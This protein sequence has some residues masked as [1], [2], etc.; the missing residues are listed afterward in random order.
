[1]PVLIT[2][3]RSRIDGQ[4]CSNTS[5]GFVM[6]PGDSASALY[7]EGRVLCRACGTAAQES[8]DGSEF[9]TIAELTEMMNEEERVRQHGED[10]PMATLHELAAKFNQAKAVAVPQPPA[11][12]AEAIP[13]ESPKPADDLGIMPSNVHGPSREARVAAL[14]AEAATLRE[15]AKGL[16][17]QAESNPLLAP[18]LEAAIKKMER[19]AAGKDK[20]ADK[21]L[22][23]VYKC[24][25]RSAEEVALRQAIYAGGIE[26]LQALDAAIAAGLFGK[27]ARPATAKS[28]GGESAKGT[29]TPRRSSSTP[30]PEK[31]RLAMRAH[32]LR[33]E[34]HTLAQVA[35][36]LGIDDPAYKGLR[37]V[38]RLLTLKVA[39]A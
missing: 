3:Q 23:V 6:L 18:A 15:G 5:K 22:P 7:K 26:A 11:P 36:K 2:C 1:M 9:I 30:D 38:Q 24:I 31:V 20:D 28:D 21:L 35:E 25:E 13:V 17:I 37:V 29:P 32:Q 16:R 19:D 34:G 10:N 4:D 39:V 8:T 14:R 33:G 12:S 27:K